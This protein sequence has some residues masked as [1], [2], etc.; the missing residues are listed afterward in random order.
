[1]VQPFA[2][3]N[4]R[5]LTFF[6]DLTCLACGSALAFDRT[7]RRQVAR[8]GSAGGSWTPCAN[9]EVIGCDWLALSAGALCG[10]CGLT[11]TRPADGRDADI[12]AWR[13]VEAG[14]RRLLV[15]LDRLG[16]TLAG[17][18]AGD[19]PLRFDLLSSAQGPIVT[20]RQGD[21]ITID[22]AEG[23][24]PH[25]EALRVQLGEP[26]RTVLGHLRHE[27]GHWFRDLL[28]R[29]GRLDRYAEAFGDD[30]AD[31]AAALRDHYDGTDDGSWQDRYVS[32]YAAA[33]PSEDWA[34]TF[35]HYL[36]IRAVLDTA[37]AWGINVDG[38]PAELRIA[39]RASLSSDPREPR[40]SFEDLIDS[41]LPLTF[42]LN[43]VNRS[44]GKDDLY[45]FVLVPPV[46]R[47]LELVHHALVRC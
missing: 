27:V 17:P 44:M 41:W 28:D 46:L 23:F 43:A 6:G 8:D 25:R 34:D 35:A 40:H 16:W 14:K 11:R 37:Q 38:P 1:V 36:H 20:G 22:L 10:S 7:G 33:H 2:C 18:P 47:K 13:V 5:S 31:Y 12:A 32:R 21:L 30:S 29:E 39:G 24:D 42:A 3:G 19:S 9:R 26:Y 45:P 15:D 4:C